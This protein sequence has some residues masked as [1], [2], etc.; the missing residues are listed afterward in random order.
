MLGCSSPLVRIPNNDTLKIAIC[1]YH[2]LLP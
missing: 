1:E 2:R